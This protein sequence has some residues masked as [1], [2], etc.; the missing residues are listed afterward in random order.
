L[1]AL[2]LRAFFLRDFFAMVRLLFVPNSPAD[3]SRPVGWPPS[4][5]E[6]IHGLMALTVSVM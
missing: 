1:A 4:R 2:F 5:P 6:L 3:R